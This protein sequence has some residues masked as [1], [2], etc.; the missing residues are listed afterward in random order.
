[1]S[2]S[3]R[4]NK[5]YLGLI[6]DTPGTRPDDAT[7]GLHADVV[8]QDDTAYI[9]YFT[10]PDRGRPETTAPTRAVDPRSR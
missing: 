8:V 5:Q 3:M 1:M 2:G 4:D 10:H 7:I 9:F 6:L